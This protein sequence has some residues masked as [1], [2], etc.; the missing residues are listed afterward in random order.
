MKNIYNY[1]LLSE[2]VREE[3]RELQYE[4]FLEFYSDEDFKYY[5]IERLREKE[6][7]FKNLEI[8]EFE[9]SYS[10][11]DYVNLSGYI[12]TKDLL[13]FT[14]KY[15]DGILGELNKWSS[16]S[17]TEESLDDIIKALEEEDDESIDII[18][19]SSRSIKADTY[20]YKVKKYVEDLFYMIQV[21]LLNDFTNS[22]DEYT[23][24][25]FEN[26][27]QDFINN[28]DF[29]EDGEVFDEYN[30]VLLINDDVKVYVDKDIIEE[31]EA[32]EDE[33]VEVFEAIQYN[34]ELMGEEI[35]V[36]TIE[37]DA[38]DTVW[39]YVDGNV[40]IYNNQI[41]DEFNELKYWEV[42]EILENAVIE[43]TLDN[44]YISFMQQVLFMKNYN[45]LNNSLYEI[46]ENLEIVN[47]C[48]D[49]IIDL[50]ITFLNH[51]NSTKDLELEKRINKYLQGQEP[52]CESALYYIAEIYYISKDGEVS[53][54]FNVFVDNLKM[55][56]NDEDIKEAIKNY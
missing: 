15:R 54:L 22:L 29:Y 28:N 35:N 13:N 41:Q 31:V 24:E 19:L 30:K 10:Q 14:K 34:L 27:F 55:F 47:P 7:I 8:S 50:K 25:D 33:I 48:A 16:F 1:S 21:E 52:S 49:K 38:N 9:I 45:K 18:N 42:D 5:Y 53:K 26:Y 37:E 43:I 46:I 3:V 4:S 40:P 20:F 44:G 36:D 32:D 56:I 51:L 6:A 17:I 2:R 11:G 39:S 23:E 12:M